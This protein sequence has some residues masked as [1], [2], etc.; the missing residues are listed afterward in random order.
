MRIIQLP[1]GT[2][3]S[4][5]Q[6]AIDNSTNGTRKINLPDYINAERLI[7]KTT[8]LS[9]LPTTV[10]DASITSNHRVVSSQITGA[11]TSFVIAWATANGSITWSL[12]SGTFSACTVDYYMGIPQ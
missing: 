8:S 2:V 4:T 9:S 11:T 3:Q 6:I 1:S 10:N 5:D 12:S 7:H